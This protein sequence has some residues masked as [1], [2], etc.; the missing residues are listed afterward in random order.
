GFGCLSADGRWQA[1]SLILPL[2]TELAWISMVLVA[3]ARRRMGLGTFLLK[4]CIEEVRSAG[5]VAGLDAPEQGR[6]IYVPLG[7]RD[8]YPISRWHFDR[9]SDAAI[10]AP[11]GVVLRTIAPAD[12]P[13]L[14][15][16]DSQRSG[17]ERAAIL[18]HLA[19][20]QPGRAW[21]AENTAAEI[22]GF[23]L[24]REGRAASSLGPVVA[25]SEAI[26][27]ALLGKA[28]AAAN[29]PFIIDVPQAHRAVRAW[30]E[31][32]GAVTPRGY[33]RMTL[34]K[35]ESLNDSTHLFALAGPE[36]G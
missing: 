2:G 28:A 36:L 12:L 22:V 35:A 20:R 5:A 25:E 33:V 32:Q 8:L 13:A 14:A 21:L 15:L 9:V 10:P 3:R 30:L 7:F 4:R 6:P 23:V 29:G 34:G 27:L 11:A 26:A 16:Y 31:C 18:A 1:T 19:A 17:M 24:G